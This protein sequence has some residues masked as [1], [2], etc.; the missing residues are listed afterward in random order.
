MRKAEEC[1][2]FSLKDELDIVVR[3][4]PQCCWI[5]TSDWSDGAEFWNCISD[6]I[7]DCTRP[8]TSRQDASIWL[9]KYRRINIQTLKWLNCNCWFL[10]TVVTSV[11]ENFN[12]RT[13]TYLYLLISLYNLPLPLHNFDSFCR[14]FYFFKSKVSEEAF[15]RRMMRWHFWSSVT[16][17]QQKERSLLGL[18]S[19]SRTSRPNAEVTGGGALSEAIMANS[20]WCDNLS[21][22]R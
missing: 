4:T 1:V 13:L 15:A 11:T 5:L 17:A 16:G 21:S 8:I 18:L 20:V 12:G 2:R 10:N 6:A 19:C 9:Y 3:S 14:L 22:R 7:M